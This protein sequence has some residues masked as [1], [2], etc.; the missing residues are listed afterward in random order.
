MIALAWVNNGIDKKTRTRTFMKEQHE[1][2]CFRCK[3]VVRGTFLVCTP[4][5]GKFLNTN[6]IILLCLQ[7]VSSAHFDFFLGCQIL[8]K[9]C[10]GV[11]LGMLRTALAK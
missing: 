6:F 2:T 10:Q 7:L 8:S 11:S 5:I 4:F 9:F 3:A 1:S